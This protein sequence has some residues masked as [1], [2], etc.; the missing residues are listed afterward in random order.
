MNNTSH[1]HADNHYAI[2][3]M[4]HTLH[5]S[6]PLTMPDDDWPTR[7]RKYVARLHNTYVHTKPQLGF[8]VPSDF[9][10]EVHRGTLKDYMVLLHCPETTPTEPELTSMMTTY[11]ATLNNE[12]ILRATN[13]AL[14]LYDPPSNESGRAPMTISDFMVLFSVPTVAE[15]FIAA[16][17]WPNGVAQCPTCQS[18]LTTVARSTAPRTEYLQQAHLTVPVGP[19]LIWTCD[20]CGSDFIAIDGTIMADMNLPPQDWFYIAMNT[21]ENTRAQAPSSTHIKPADTFLGAEISYE[22]SLTIHG[23]LQNLVPAHTKPDALGTI[24][25]LATAEPAN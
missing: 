11:A 4:A 19:D 6:P 21:I 1:R 22:E 25:R 23:R 14:Y 18:S 12:A 16:H 10:H 7:V 17:R 20:T 15:V 3:H 9:I 8:S 13:D 2:A 24:K 5:T